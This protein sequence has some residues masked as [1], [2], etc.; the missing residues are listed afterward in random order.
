MDEEGDQP[1]YAQMINHLGAMLVTA[2]SE[3]DDYADLMLQ[4][5]V[6]SF[7][8]AYAWQGKAYAAFEDQRYDDSKRYIE[9]AQRNI[10]KGTED[11]VHPRYVELLDVLAGE[12]TKLASRLQG[13]ASISLLHE[14]W[15]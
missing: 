8:H 5:F 3:A 6:S 15:R 7:V 1:I 14:Y 11:A 4:M 12:V 9:E 10:K 13:G 2:P